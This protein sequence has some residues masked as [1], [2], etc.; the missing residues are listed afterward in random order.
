MTRGFPLLANNLFF[1]NVRDLNSHIKQ[2]ELGLFCSKNKVGL[3]ALSETKLRPNKLSECKRR[4]F[5]SWESVDNGHCHSTARLWVLWR[6]EEYEVSILDIQV[7]YMHME[8]YSKA[9]FQSF[10]I[11]TIY[12]S[13]IASDRMQLWDSLRTLQV[14]ATWLAAGDFNN[15]LTSDE[16]EGGNPP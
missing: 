7:Q 13:N 5:P 16:R 10:V 6:A 9:L 8:V 4:I 14:T 1:W 15:V 3:V 12:A 2:R 11:T